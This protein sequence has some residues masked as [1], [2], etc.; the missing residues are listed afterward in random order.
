MITLKEAAE[1][2]AEQY[3]LS[4]FPISRIRQWITNGKLKAIKLG[5]KYYVNPEDLESYLLE[6]SQEFN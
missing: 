4:S 6:I 2:V 3:K 5:R 1:K